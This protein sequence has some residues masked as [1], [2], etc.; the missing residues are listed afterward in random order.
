[1]MEREVVGFVTLKCDSCGKVFR[2][3]NA[4]EDQVRGLKCIKCGGHTTVEETERRI[5]TK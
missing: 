4:R 3:P 1:M 5:I 2:V